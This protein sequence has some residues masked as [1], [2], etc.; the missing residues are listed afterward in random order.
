MTPPGIDTSLSATARTS[1]RSAP[2]A[3]SAAATTW[4]VA[5]Y[6]AGRPSSALSLRC[7]RTRS[8]PPLRDY[9]RRP[10]AATTSRTPPSA[11][12]PHAQRVRI[13]ICELAVDAD[14]RSVPPH[15]LWL[16]GHDT[17]HGRWRTP[18][19]TR[20]RSVR[21][22]VGALPRHPC[23][24]HENEHRAA[25]RQPINRISLYQNRTVALV[26]R[27]RERRDS[28]ESPGQAPYNHTSATPTAHGA[29]ADPPEAFGLASTSFERGGSPWRAGSPRRSTPP[30]TSPSA[31]LRS[32][33][34]TPVRAPERRGATGRADRGARPGGRCEPGSASEKVARRETRERT[35]VAVHLVDAFVARITTSTDSTDGQTGARRRRRRQCGWRPCHRPGRSRPRGS[36]KHRTPTTSRSPGSRSSN[37]VCAREPRPYGPILPRQ[38]PRTP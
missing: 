32:R 31:G 33:T 36:K 6:R 4:A 12:A 28:A 11:H 19:G 7:R 8:K 35:G 21:R 20:S 30:S 3:H 2:A 13:G 38:Y 10:P 22:P 23:A 14:V 18:R 15:A 37:N 29:I 27:P 1:R 16:Q 34:D 5:R 24:I 9:T 26:K 25:A 17:S